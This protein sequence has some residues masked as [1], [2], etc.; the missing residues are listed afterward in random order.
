[1]TLLF[2]QGA[3]L[4][5]KI[6]SLVCHEGKKKMCHWL[7]GQAPVEDER[8]RLVWAARFSGMTHLNQVIEK[9]KDVNYFRPY[10]GEYPLAVAIHRGD[11]EIVRALLGAGAKAGLVDLIEAAYQGE[12]MTSLIVEQG[13][14]PN[15]RLTMKEAM[16]FSADWAG[17]TPLTAVAG[18]DAV[19]PLRALQ[20][21]GASLSRKNE[22]GQTPLVAAASAC[23][24]FSTKYIAGEL[25]TIS[26]EER[27]AARTAAQRNR[28]VLLAAWLRARAPDTSDR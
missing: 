24:Y 17:E 23:A 22:Q 10:I 16:R 28:C 18:D 11:C 25:G 4:N 8:Y 12:A 19:G 27:L 3:Q 5:A 20:Q 9:Q 26:S 15:R 14:D 6:L 1:M 21:S 13:I 7:I 2:G